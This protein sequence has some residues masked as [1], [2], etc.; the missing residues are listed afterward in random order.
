MTAAVLCATGAFL[1][2]AVPFSWLLARMIR[3]VDIRGVGSGNIGATNVARS[4]GLGPGLLALALDVAKG[5][6]AVLLARWLLAGD[7]R[8][9]VLEVIAGGMAILGHNFTPFLRF[10]GGKGVATGAGVFGVL[11]PWALLG[12]VLVFVL[13]VAIGRMVSLG[14]VLAAVSL[15]IAVLALGG[16][17]E[18]G[19]I[20]VLVA[21]LVIV[22]HRANLQ[23]ILAGKENRLGGG[24]TTT[25]GRS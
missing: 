20:S 23:R 15:P 6:A 16:R 3:G 8:L 5:S 14:S 7:A 22:R 11:A 24:R 9:P 17:R 19:V 13:V 21:V 18:I 1:L 2:G 4:I 25:G 10:R 12:A